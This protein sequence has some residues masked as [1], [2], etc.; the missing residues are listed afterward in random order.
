MPSNGNQLTYLSDHKAVPYF[1][2]LLQY[3]HHHHHHRRLS[4]ARFLINVTMTQNP[5]QK[6][7]TVSYIWQGD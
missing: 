2:I 5:Q 7:K 6:L 1:N 4:L 3:H